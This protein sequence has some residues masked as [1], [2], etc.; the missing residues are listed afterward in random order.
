MNA[1]ERRAALELEADRIKK[2]LDRIERQLEG[3][4]DGWFHLTQNLPETVAEVTVDKS[5]AEARQQAL[6][7]ATI[8]KLLDGSSAQETG[9]AAP[10]A[11]PADEIRA[12]R[13][14]RLKKAQGQT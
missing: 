14:A 6:A 10:A 4:P 8:V 1:A 5:L 2:R 11:T 13:E 3:D 12:A 9:S 7:L